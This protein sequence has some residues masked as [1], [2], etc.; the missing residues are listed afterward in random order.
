MIIG[1]GTEG[2]RRRRLLADRGCRRIRERHTAGR[3][4]GKSPLAAK[5]KT[6][7]AFEQVR[8]YER[9]IPWLFYT[10]AINVITNGVCTRFG[11][12]CA[13]SDY[14]SESK[15][16]WPLLEPGRL[17]DRIAHV[18]VF[19]RQGD[20]ETKKI[21]RYQQFRAVNKIV[22]RVVEKEHRSEVIW[23]TQG[24]ASR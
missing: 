12:T 18:I 3:D 2:P 1:R 8:Q 16:P 22:R 13:A 4:R 24:A 20:E 11:A 21:C 6:G 7:E 9:E 5:D 14:W 23:H 19:E 17:L 15:G 10:N